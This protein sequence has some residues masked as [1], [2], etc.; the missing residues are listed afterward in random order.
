MPLSGGGKPAGGQAGFGEGDTEIF[1]RGFGFRFGFGF[2][3]GVAV[4]LDVDVG[5]T[6]VFVVGFVVAL[7]VLF[8]VALAVALA[9]ALTETFAVAFAVG[10]GFFVAACAALPDIA[11]ANTRKSATFLNRAPT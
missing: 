4:L 11:S 9:V 6:E 8:T 2:A 5:L 3:V 7:A 10:V 1:L